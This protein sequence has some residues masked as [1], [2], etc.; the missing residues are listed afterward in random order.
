VKMAA[1]KE[2]SSRIVELTRFLPYAYNL[3]CE[4]LL[5]LTAANVVRRT[6]AA[7]PVP[8][9]WQYASASDFE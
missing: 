5:A 2:G 4:A 7:H 8:T 9:R 6:A 1:V 3:A